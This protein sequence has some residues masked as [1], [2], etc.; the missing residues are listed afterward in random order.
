MNIPQITS[1]SDIKMDECYYLIDK[2]YNTTIII[3]IKGLRIGFTIQDVQNEDFLYQEYSIPIYNF[4]QFKIQVIYE[5]LE[6]L[7]D[8]DNS[9]N[10]FHKLTNTKNEYYFLEHML[11]PISNFTLLYN[12]YLCSSTICDNELPIKTEC[13][14]CYNPICTNHCIQACI[15]CKKI[16]HSDCIAKYFFLAPV[17]NKN[18]CPHCRFQKFKKYLTI[19]TA[20]MA[21]DEHHDLRYGGKAKAKAKAKKKSKKSKS[22]NKSKK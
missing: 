7:Y 15:E 4:K 10:R 6:L 8:E 2:N 5:V 13:L 9:A 20:Q 17:S 18:K 22:K 1:L 21:L 3:K 12:L 19:T 16:F 11:K 14:I